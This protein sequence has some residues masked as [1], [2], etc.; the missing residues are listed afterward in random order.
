MKGSRSMAVVSNA[1]FPFCVTDWEF[2][3]SRWYNRLD[4]T[5]CSL[6][7]LADIC[8]RWHRD[9]WLEEQ[10]GCVW[11]HLALSTYFGSFKIRQKWLLTK[12]CTKLTSMASTTQW[13]K[14]TAHC[15]R[16]VSW[17]MLS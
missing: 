6:Y 1:T 13:R 16:Q 12:S 10:H 9:R 3:P 14:V 17:A 4:C 8:T 15:F 5:V 2:S 11:L 7:C